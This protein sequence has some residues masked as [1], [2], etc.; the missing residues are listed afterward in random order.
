MPE[1]TFT[2]TGWGAVAILVVAVGLFGFRVLTMRNLENNEKLVQEVKMLLQAEYLPDDVK[3]ME[4]LYES[5][6]TEE[7]GKAVQS[8]ATTSISIESIKAGFPTLNFD[9][10]RKRVVTKVVYAI[11]DDSGVRQEGTKYYAFDYAPLVNSWQF[12]RE[13]TMISYYLNLF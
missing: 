8:L 12:G 13:V 2:L 3:N 5:G 11:A 7:L 10:K 9:S 4:N 6:K 1:K